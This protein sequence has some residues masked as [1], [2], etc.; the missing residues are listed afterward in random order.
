LTKSFEIASQNE[1][2]LISDLPKGIYLGVIESG[3]NKYT[4]KIIIN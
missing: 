2:I 3:N 4:K 1:P